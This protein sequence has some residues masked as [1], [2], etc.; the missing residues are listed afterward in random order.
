MHFLLRSCEHY[1]RQ[2]LDGEGL[3]KMCYLSQYSFR[4]KGVSYLY[5]VVYAFS[6]TEL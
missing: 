5:L 1:D 3:V 2:S 4:N 6:V